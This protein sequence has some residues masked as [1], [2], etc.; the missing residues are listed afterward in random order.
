MSHEGAEGDRTHFRTELSFPRCVSPF[1]EGTCRQAGR[2]SERPSRRQGGGSGRSKWES[3][4]TRNLCLL[5]TKAVSF[6]QPVSGP[7]GLTRFLSFSCLHR[8]WGGEGPAGS[9]TFPLPE[10]QSTAAASRR[11]SR[12]GSGRLASSRRPGVLGPGSYAT[13]PIPLPAL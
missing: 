8:T 7:M 6:T 12:R 4:C 1:G 3:S 2:S 11:L 5:K 9:P 10:G 13:L